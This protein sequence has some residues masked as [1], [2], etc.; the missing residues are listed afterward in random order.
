M[1]IINLDTLSNRVHKTLVAI[2]TLSPNIQ[3]PI[4]NPINKK[5][6][7]RHEIWLLDPTY[8]LLLRQSQT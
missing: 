6:I 5:M 1:T 3:R 7:S 4:Q 8:I 2:W